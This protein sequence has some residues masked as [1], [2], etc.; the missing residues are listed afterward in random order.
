MTIKECDRCG[1]QVR[2]ATAEARVVTTLLTR[3]RKPGEHFPSK[4][5]SSEM[6]VPCWQF[7]EEG[8]L[9]LTRS[10]LLAGRVQTIQGDTQ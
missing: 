7:V 3:E 1:A 4:T 8:F 6:C 5:Y 10:E 2:D 9:R